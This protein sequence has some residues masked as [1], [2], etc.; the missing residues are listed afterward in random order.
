MMA[1][2]KVVENSLNV[3]LPK[4]YRDF[5]EYYGLISNEQGEVYGYMEG[6]DVNKIPSVIAATK[7]YRDDYLN[8]SG[9]EIIISFD[10][11]YNAPIVLNTE[12]GAV[13]RVFRDRKEK[14]NK[15]FQEWLTNFLNGN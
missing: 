5:L 12:D 14:I 15:S 3:N 2:F 13:Y 6:I 1:R 11:F 7:L 9:K 4:E 10:D 8:I